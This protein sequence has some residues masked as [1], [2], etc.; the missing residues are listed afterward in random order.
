MQGPQGLTGP[1]GKVGDTGGQEPQGPQG[2]RGPQGPQGLKGDKGDAG[3]QGLKGDTGSQCP[4]GDKGDKGDTG[5]QGPKGDKGDAASGGLTDAGFTMKTGI[6]MGNHEVTN[7]GTPTTNSRRVTLAATWKGP[8][9][10]TRPALPARNFPSKGGTPARTRRT[11]SSTQTCRRPGIFYEIQ[12]QGGGS[13]RDHGF[14]AKKFTRTSCIG[15]P[16]YGTRT[17]PC[18]P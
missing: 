17:A 14:Y 15:N 8:G 3:P 4:K 1:R 16:G 13:L 10:T 6:D 18:N 2:L 7:L 9:E 11:S 5:N 12:R